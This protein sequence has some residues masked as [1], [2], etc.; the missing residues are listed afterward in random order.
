MIGKPIRELV[1]T[2]DDPLYGLSARY[3][4]RHL[5]A[6]GLFRGLGS[7]RCKRGEWL[8][9]RE[10]VAEIQRRLRAVPDEEPVELDTPSGLSSRSRTLR[11]I[12]QGRAAS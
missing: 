2:E 5:E 3:V 7:Q 1:A 4:R 6:G 9:N 10:D 8:L 12:Q 11:R